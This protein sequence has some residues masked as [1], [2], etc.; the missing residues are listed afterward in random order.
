VESK[1][2][3]VYVFSKHAEHFLVPDHLT[4]AVQ[5]SDWSLLFNFQI[6]DCTQFIAICLAYFPLRPNNSAV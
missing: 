4:A 1:V 6:A 5:N 3:W 2:V